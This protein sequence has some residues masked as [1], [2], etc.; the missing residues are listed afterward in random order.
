MEIIGGV[1]GFLV[2]RLS[3]AALSNFILI[4]LPLAIFCLQVTR[5]D[6]VKDWLANSNFYQNIITETP[7]LIEQTSG[8]STK[9][10]GDILDA[11]SSINR[12]AVES[13]IIEAIDPRALQQQTELAIDHIYSWLAGDAD[14]LDFTVGIEPQ[15]PALKIA[16][17]AELANQLLAL[18]R[19]EGPSQFENGLLSASCLPVGYD[20]SAKVDAYVESL[21]G[22]NGFIGDG[23][24]VAA[25]VNLTNDTRTRARNAYRLGQSMPY[26]VG[27]GLA[28]LTPLALLGSKS[29]N[30]GLRRVGT[31]FT[32]A[33]FFMTLAAFAGS[34]MSQL[35]PLADGLFGAE[36]AG[37]GSASRSIVE[38]L[39]VGVIRDTSRPLLTMTL[40]LLVLGIAML[41]AARK[42][43]DIPASK[44]IKSDRYVSS[45]TLRKYRR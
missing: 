30:L 16:L 22:P 6:N 8:S 5:A 45:R 17:K 13:V 29:R 32:S 20:T 1:L 35:P 37:V 23:E 14:R 40:A 27:M 19:C 26:I 39:L 12:A 21:L 43:R 2:R 7:G 38:P 28:I 4:G 44:I 42:D 41:V 31:L 24:I 34:R 18:P 25:D 3:M 10:L 15:L 9:T 33:G 11:N 36:A